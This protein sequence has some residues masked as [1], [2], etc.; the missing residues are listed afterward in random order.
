MNSRTNGAQISEKWCAAA[1]ATL[2]PQDSLPALAEKMRIHGDSRRKWD[3]IMDDGLWLN[4]GDH[5]RL[6]AALWLGMKMAQEGFSPMYYCNGS[7]DPKDARQELQTLMW[8]LRNLVP[9]HARSA[10]IFTQLAKAA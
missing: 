8:R 7:R 3:A 2:L 10:P 6:T 1:K 5:A 4:G 9:K